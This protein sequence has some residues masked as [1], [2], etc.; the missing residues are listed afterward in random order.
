[1]SAR[2]GAHFVPIGIPTICWKTFPA[3]TTKTMS[4]RTSSIL[5]TSSSEYLC[6]ESECSSDDSDESMILRDQKLDICICDYLFL[7]M[8]EF[9]MI[10]ASLFF[11]LS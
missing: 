8:K 3:K 11:S 7:N 10:L 1:M 4:T 9:R 2:R 6:L 5:M